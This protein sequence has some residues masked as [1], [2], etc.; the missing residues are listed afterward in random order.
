MGIIKSLTCLLEIIFNKH[1]KKGELSQERELR[2]MEKRKH[3]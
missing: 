2:L 1:F 3:D